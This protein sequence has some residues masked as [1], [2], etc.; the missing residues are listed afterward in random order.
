MKQKY[1]TKGYVVVKL[2][3]VS[4]LPLYFHEY[5]QKEKVGSSKVASQEIYTLLVLES[6]HLDHLCMGLYLMKTH[7][8]DVKTNF[9]VW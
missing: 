5:P 7:Y 9:V 3:L 2:F 1:Q 8:V 6:R 4:I